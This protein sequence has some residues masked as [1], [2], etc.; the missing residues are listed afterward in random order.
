MTDP[1]PADRFD[2]DVLAHFLDGEHRAARQRVK[3]AMVPHA[4]LLRDS[5]GMPT[6]DYRRRVRDVVTE[7][8]SGGTTGLGFPKE[9]GGGGDIGASIASFETLAYS[10]LSVLVKMGVQFG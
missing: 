10:D 6:A 1:G 3:E 9:Y 5:I 8:A 2:P 7:V 4:K